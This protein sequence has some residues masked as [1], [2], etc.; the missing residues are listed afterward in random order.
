MTLLLSFFFTSSL[1]SPS[2]MNSSTGPSH[3]AF[4]P[5]PFE[6]SPG[7]SPGLVTRTQRTYS[8]S[9]PTFAL[10]HQTPV[11]FVDPGT[12]P[13]P[14]RPYSASGPFPFS[15]T[16]PYPYYMRSPTQT[17][18]MD[19]YQYPR[20]GPSAHGHVY[21]PLV[22]PVSDTFIHE[23][24]K[25]VIKNKGKFTCYFPSPSRS[26]PTPLP[27]SILATP[28]LSVAPLPT[29][30]PALRRTPAMP[31]SYASP[32][33]P[34]VQLRPMPLRTPFYLD[35]HAS[36]IQTPP[37]AP[38]LPPPIIPPVF[39]VPRPL[40]THLTYP[41]S[42]KVDLPDLSKIPLLSSGADW[43]TWFCGVLDM[44]DNLCLFHHISPE[45]TPGVFPDRMSALSYPPT[46]L[47]SSSPEDLAYHD[48]WWRADGT[49]WHILRGRL[50]PG[51]DVMPMGF[52][53]RLR[54]IFLR[55]F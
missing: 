19:P 24:H 45:P 2:C 28:P 27:T 14:F 29:T 48:T 42:F 30:L 21:S 33:T 4:P 17:D 25:S 7:G 36:P 31:H 35:I 43:L 13:R 34:S 18:P 8:H 44:V 20:P 54:G 52:F 3:P 51:P 40:P 15:A 26:L 11:P 55:Y 39:D 12:T 22:S 10:T 6:R 23:Y 46:L 32:C 53:M 1:D 47:P 37:L 9:W 38:A 49:V 41:R 16:V 5:T 50:G